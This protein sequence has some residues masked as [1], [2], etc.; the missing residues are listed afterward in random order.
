MKSIAEKIERV[1]PMERFIVLARE[2]DRLKEVVSQL[3]EGRSVDDLL[4][5]LEVD[6]LSERFSIS[7]ALMRKK[8]KMAGGKVVKMGKKYVIRKVNF[9]EVLQGLEESG[10]LKD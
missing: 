5:L 8:L 6:E 1:S 3:D 10:S 7:P 2:M 4:D 9:L